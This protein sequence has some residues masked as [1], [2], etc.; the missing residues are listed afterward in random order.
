MNNGGETFADWLNTEVTEASVVWIAI[1]LI[2]AAILGTAI[3]R[4]YVRYGTSLSNRQAFAKNF[5]LLTMT[6][7]L[8]IALIQTNISLSLGMIGALSIVRFRSA[9]KEP[10]EL[11]Y[12]FLSIAVGLGLGAQQGVLTVGALLVILFVL[13]LKSRSTSKEAGRVEQNLYLTIASNQPSVVSV[14]ALTNLLRN[15]CSLFRLKRMDRTGVSTEACYMVEPKDAQAISALETELRQLDADATLT[16]L[17]TH[18]GLL[19]AN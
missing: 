12:L 3:G 4:F 6:T 10:E 1:Y 19:G 7:T 13:W 16:L 8:I 11:A 5:V 9:I 15:H 14:D 18:G 17:D 2:L